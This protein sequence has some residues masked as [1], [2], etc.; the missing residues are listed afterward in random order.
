MNKLQDLYHERRCD[1]FASANHINITI[2]GSIHGL[3]YD[4]L[5]SSSASNSKRNTN[6]V[7]Q[8]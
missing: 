2:D 6:P 7:D 1:G 3:G 4:G 5:V 8:W